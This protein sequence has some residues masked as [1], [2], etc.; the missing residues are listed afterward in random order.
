MLRGFGTAALPS[1]G[2]TGDVL[3]R[4][5]ADPPRVHD[6]GGGEL[7]SL[8][9]EAA[10]YALIAGRCRAGDRT[11]ETG[12]G[13][14]TALFG[15]LGTDHTC[16]TPS[17]AEVERLRRYC[18]ARGVPL[19]RVTFA[20][21]SSTEVL[22]TLAPDPLDVVLIDGS[23]GFPVPVLDWYYAGGRLRRGGL[24]VVDD[25]DLPAVGLLVGFLDA[26]PRWERVAG[27]AKW[28]AYERRSE[29]TLAEEWVDQPFFRMPPPPLV[30]R[31]AAA[32]VAG[33]RSLRGLVHN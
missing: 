24:L 18:A 29:G 13:L 1:A 4:L 33:L 27:T 15:A 32:V 3:A 16:V 7:A 19:E 10:C 9:T 30:R 2:V 8:G 26:D 5:L 28:R 11:L 6:M 14:S 25:V 22:P 31:L 17:S 21:G 12:L 20:V 23:H